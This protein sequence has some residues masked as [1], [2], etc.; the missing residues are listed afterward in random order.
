MFIYRPN[1]TSLVLYGV[2]I[3]KFCTVSFTRIENEQIKINRKSNIHKL[4]LLPLSNCLQS[5]SDRRQRLNTR[6]LSV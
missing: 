5:N 1:S 3:S 6:Q 2:I 4:Q